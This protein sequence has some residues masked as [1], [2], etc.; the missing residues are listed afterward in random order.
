MSGSSAART[1]G[2]SLVIAP[3]AACP[4]TARRHVTATLSGVARPELVDVAALAVTELA[5]N[6][7]LHART[8]VSVAVRLL[9]GD[10]V[11]IEV[12]DGSPVMPL[13]HAERPT[14]TVG[15]GLHLLDSLGRWG[16]EP[17]LKDGRVTG[18]VVWFTPAGPGS[19][20]FA[21]PLAGT[22]GGAAGHAGADGPAG[23]GP[24]AR[25]GPR[26]ADEPADAGASAAPEGVASPGVATPPNDADGAL[27]RYRA[28]GEV[29]DT[30]AEPALTVRL[31]NF[32]LQLFLDVREH[33]DE[34][35]REFALLAM[36][37]QD[38]PQ[39]LQRL[40]ERL[41][42]LVDLLGRRFG[43]AGERGHAARDAAIV[44]GDPAADLTYHV[45]RSTAEG[46]VGLAA[47]L[48]EADAFCA[49]GWLLTMP[50][51]S[52]HRE[53]VVWYTGEFVRQRDGLPATPWPG[54]TSPLEF[55]RP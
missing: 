43:A 21:G 9:P 28:D 42:D 48:E 37:A 10:Q 7:A 32:P 6:A 44:R 1:A 29:I 31:L 5:T 55:D 18:K 36:Q 38:D 19:T 11:R 39:A 25:V 17:V 20:D 30:V 14:S 16:V 12:G 22:D 23:A 46:L 4:A 35:L 27:G 33:H 34:L 40:P 49:A 3:D 54:P 45:T 13:E 41:G 47:L 52:L 53:F 15:R 26:V 2:P 51:P 24:P 50:R 8:P